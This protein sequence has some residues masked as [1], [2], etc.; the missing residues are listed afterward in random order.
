LVVTFH[1][2]QDK[3]DYVD[4]A[5]VVTR[6]VEWSELSRR[7]RLVKQLKLS[8]Q[9]VH[10][11]AKTGLSR[12]QLAAGIK[13][14]MKQAGK[15][16]VPDLGSRTQGVH[17]EY[18][19]ELRKIGVEFTSVERVWSF[20]Q[21]P[22]FKEFIEARAKERAE[23]SDRAKKNTIK[24][25]LVSLFGKMLEN[26]EGHRTVK[27][28]TK[29]S[30]FQQAV[31]KYRMIKQ[32]SPFYWTKYLAYSDGSFEF[33]ALT[34]HKKRGGPILDTPRI[35][36]WAIL[37]Y[38]KMVML[39]FHYSVMKV[40]FADLK[41]L[42]TDTDSLYYLIMS[43]EN[44]VDIMRR[45][46]LENGQFAEFDLSEFNRYKDCQNKGVLGKKKVECGDNTI[47]A[48][49][50]LCAKCYAKDTPEKVERKFKGMPKLQLKRLYNFESYRKALLQNDTVPA[51]FLA[52]RSVDHRVRHCD[53]TRAGLT[54]DNDKVFLVS[55]TESR[56]L[57]HHKNS[58]A[59]PP[60]PEWD[61]ETTQE[62]EDLYQMAVDMLRQERARVSQ[63]SQENLDDNGDDATVA[64]ADSFD[65]M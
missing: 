11:G 9:E 1:V 44:P 17:V 58:E 10:K 43:A 53:I 14:A 55:P 56:P 33:L 35:I 30:T 34:Y 7:Q 46:N 51:K 19:Q 37:D 31:S 50:G 25:F 2:P 40:C 8:Q 41:L 27:L 24:L 47:E 54:A 21:A 26:K 12:K 16:L 48:F 49:V 20:R 23:T 18:A 28:H 3:H 42:M 45:L 62:D 60:C 38:A 63:E 59:V 6:T 61:L 4:F 22:V 65:D 57:G 5:P 29:P 13:N 39:R 36:G 64:T 15:K 32:K 52:F